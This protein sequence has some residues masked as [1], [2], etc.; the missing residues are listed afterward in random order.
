MNFARPGLHLRFLAAAAQKRCRKKSIIYHLRSGRFLADILNKYLQYFKQWP[1]K[2]V[3]ELRL[4]YRQCEHI[5]VIHCDLRQSLCSKNRTGSVFLIAVIV[6][7]QVYLKQWV[8]F[9]HLKNHTTKYRK[10]SPGPNVPGS[11]PGE[12]FISENYNTLWYWFLSLVCLTCSFWI[13]YIN[14]KKKLKSLLTNW[15]RS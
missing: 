15:K 1:Y 9:L 7:P 5:L 11:I 3:S 13:R 2:I 12:N 4:K 14:L 10:W 6:Y 8:L